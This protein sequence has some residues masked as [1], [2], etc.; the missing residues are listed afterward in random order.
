LIA[1]ATAAF[2]RGYAPS[3]EATLFSGSDGALRA[4]ARVKAP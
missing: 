3:A 4:A 2:R 1:V